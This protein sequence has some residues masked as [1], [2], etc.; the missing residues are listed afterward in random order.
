MCVDRRQRMV[1]QQQAADPLAKPMRPIRY[2][3]AEFVA[4]FY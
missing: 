3:A 1:R 2:L 4:Q